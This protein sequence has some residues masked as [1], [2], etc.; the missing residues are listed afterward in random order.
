MKKLTKRRAV[1][2]AVVVRHGP[3]F[4]PVT[5]LINAARHRAFQAVNTELIELYWRVGKYISRKLDSAVWG[6]SVVDDLARYIKRQHP[7]LKGFARPNLFRMRQFF[8]TYRHD[9][10]VSTLL[11]QLSW[12][13]HL[14]IFSRCKR[15]EAREFYLRLA[16]A[17]RLSFRELER[18]INGCLFERA[19][20]QPPKVSTVL[21]QL[22]PVAET[23]F[24]DS[25]LLDFLDLPDEHS[26]R[27]LQKALIAN[28][29]Q[30][31]IELGPDFCFVAEELRLSVG[32][33]D[34]HLDLLF[35]HRELQCLIAFDL[36]IRNFEPGD[37]GKMGFYLEAL[38]RDVKKPH[39]RPSIGVLLCASKDDEVVKYALSRSV[40]P[41]LIAEY[42]LRLPDKK[43]LQRK[44]HEFY[45]LALPPAERKKVRRK[46]RRAKKK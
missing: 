27:D 34:F 38:D 8:E 32:G 40:S 45:Q 11:R 31:L 9:A 30:F 26:E 44:L 20:L 42:Q 21:R 28:L 2:Q 16:A 39:E 15:P 6:E 37:L 24:K 3:D 46:K 23:L 35:F 4:R 29:K 5:A 13:H 12:S 7:E 25:Y 41:A 43:L 10:K 22:H 19:V 36:K 17:R 18:E 14:L 1:S 33:T